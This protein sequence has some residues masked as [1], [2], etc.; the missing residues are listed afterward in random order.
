VVAS[1]VA[2]ALKHWVVKAAVPSTSMSP[3]SDAFIT[4]IVDQWVKVL[5]C[6]AP[7]QLSGNCRKVDK[8]ATNQKHSWSSMGYIPVALLTIRVVI[9]C[10]F[11]LV[12]LNSQSGDKIRTRNTPH[13]DTTRQLREHV[14]PASSQK[15]QFIRGCT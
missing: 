14:V 12:C 11:A 3:H 10:R 13:V 6:T 15:S 5:S 2:V 4:N 9:I 1:Q 8:N 7:P